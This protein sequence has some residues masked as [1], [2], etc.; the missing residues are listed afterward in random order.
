MEGS[1]DGVYLSLV[2]PI[3][4]T[5]FVTVALFEEHG[6]KVGVCFTRGK[7]RCLL[8]FD[9]WNYL[10]IFLTGTLTHMSLHEEHEERE[11][12]KIVN[13]NKGYVHITDSVGNKFCFNHNEWM[14]FIGLI[15]LL[16]K[17]VVRL[18]YDQDYFKSYIDQVV[19]TGS[20]VSPTFF[21]PTFFIEPQH[22]RLDN[23]LTFDRLYDELVMHGKVV[24]GENLAQ[25][26]PVSV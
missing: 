4:V 17:Y 2:Y 7:K 3:G 26:P 16:T 24:V 9:E 5:K 18:F 13:R 15:P 20:Y 21:F 14:C 8:D 19:A 10:I 11:N 6:Y 1:C 12:K 23:Q 22:S 25:S